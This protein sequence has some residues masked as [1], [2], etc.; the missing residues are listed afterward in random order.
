M[1]S[2]NKPLCYEP[3]SSITLKITM[4][5]LSLLCALEV[6]DVL[7]Q[8]IQMLSPQNAAKKLIYTMFVAS[9]VIFV[10]ILTAYLVQD[11]VQV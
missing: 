6:R 5:I 1:G 10:T 9:L 11:R 7:H 8:C 2:D 3:V 4:A